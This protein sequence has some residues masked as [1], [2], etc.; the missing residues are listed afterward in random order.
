MRR[1]DR[2]VRVIALVAW[3]AFIWYWSGQADLPIDQPSVANI[4]RG[5]QHR[6]AHLI[7]FGIL[8]LLSQWALTGAPRSAWLA[9]LLTSIYGA[10]D[11]YHQ[12]FTP[13]RR[14]AIDDW[15]MDTTSGALL[16]YLWWRLRPRLRP[17]IAAVERL[18]T[19]VLF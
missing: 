19:A 14:S 10:T 12:S 3:M 17:A 5:W 11:E 7:G 16:V 1:A 9:V 13:G 15:L 4:L 6:I 2:A 8:G 18:R